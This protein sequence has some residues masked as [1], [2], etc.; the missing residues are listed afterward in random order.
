MAHI[1]KLNRESLKREFAVYVVIIHGDH[2]TTLYIGKTGD[3]REG[4][5]PIISRCGNHFSYNKIHSQVRNKIDGHEE[6]EYT[7]VFD[8]FGKYSEDKKERKSQIDLINE[9][10]RWL[11]QEIQKL[12]E[13][14][15]CVVVNPYKG[16]G[17]VKQEEKK[18]RRLFRTSEN[19]SKIKSIVNA[20]ATEIKNW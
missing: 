8:H 19:Q 4:C 20:V 14:S 7:Y 10:E 5:N 17:F 16:T 9:M 3:N 15:N 1:F 11:N 6:C 13:N 12:S 18:Y 2:E